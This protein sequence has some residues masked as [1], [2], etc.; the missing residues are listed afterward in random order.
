MRSQTLSQRTGVNES[1][2]DS[3]QLFFGFSNQPKESDADFLFFLQF[4]YSLVL[5]SLARIAI[6]LEYVEFSSIPC[7]EAAFVFSATP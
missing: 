3:L 4:L 1:N 5:Y 2:G 7:P 6:F